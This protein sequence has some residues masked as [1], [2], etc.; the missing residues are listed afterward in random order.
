MDCALGH[1]SAAKDAADQACLTQ[2][3]SGTGPGYAG[4]VA[5]EIQARSAGQA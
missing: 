2:P 1:T 5:P 4:G 3:Q